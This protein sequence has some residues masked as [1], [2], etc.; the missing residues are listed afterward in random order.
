MFDSGRSDSNFSRLLYC[1]EFDNGG[2]SSSSFDLGV[3]LL[4]DFR[5]SGVQ[6]Q[7]ESEPF[8]CVAE[9]NANRMK[10]EIDMDLR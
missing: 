8:R 5:F 9:R 2:L 6:L 4:S 10:S 7:T 1:K 3:R